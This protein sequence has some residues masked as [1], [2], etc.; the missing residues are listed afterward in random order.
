MGLC[1]VGPGDRILD[2]GAGAG[3]ALE[4]FNLTN[5]IV[6]VD[7]EPLQSEWMKIP[8]STVKVADATKLPFVDREF[9]VAFSSSVIEHIPKELQADFASEISRVGERY[10]VQTPNRYFPIRAP[11]PVAVLPVSPQAGAPGPQQA[12][13]LGVE[14]EG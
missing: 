6:A 7:L 5:E 4:R 12:F 10:Y 14:G 2:V 8:M 3:A 13:H 11:L 9:P 1:R